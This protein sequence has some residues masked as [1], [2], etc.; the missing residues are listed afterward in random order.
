MIK[1]NFL[2]FKN[3]ISLYFILY[4]AIILLVVFVII[5]QVVKK[6]VNHHINNEINTELNRHFQEIEFEN[7]NIIPLKKSYWQER[8]HISHTVNPVFV[9]IFNFNKTTID[10]SPN[11]I[12]E[13][14]ILK[15]RD[16]VFNDVE[17]NN[18]AIRQIQ[19]CST[20]FDAP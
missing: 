4:S 2:S 10:H 19:K 16:N 5:F 13:K 12:C 18:V 11:L 3:R 8:E 14:L 7:E 17:L 9:Q 20:T 1:T 15:L 6:S